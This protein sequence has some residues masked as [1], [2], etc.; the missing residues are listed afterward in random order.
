MA[1]VLAI[2][3]SLNNSCYK[4]LFIKGPPSAKTKAKQ[5]FINVVI[6]RKSSTYILCFDKFYGKA[7]LLFHQ[8]KKFLPAIM[9]IFLILAFFPS[10][11]SWK[12]YH[13]RNFSCQNLSIYT[14]LLL[15][16]KILRWSASRICKISYLLGMHM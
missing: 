2:G 1:F 8:L 16:T 10:F 5:S 4:D 11:H 14:Y 9:L 13:N 7:W 15:S 12:K 6:W 3:G